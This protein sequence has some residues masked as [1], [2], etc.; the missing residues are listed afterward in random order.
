[1]CMSAIVL[2]VSVQVLETSS[3]RGGAAEIFIDSIFLDTRSS[4]STT[5]T[6]T[7]YPPRPQVYL[8][9]LYNFV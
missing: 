2:F 1:M 6:G 7:L 3:Y 5:T 4:D 8:I 9:S